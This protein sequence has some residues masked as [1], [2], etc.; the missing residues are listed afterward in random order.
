MGVQ[1]G[2]LDFKR[3]DLPAFSALTKRG[4]PF[5]FCTSYYEGFAGDC[6]LT[7]Y[8]DGSYQ[9]TRYLLEHGHRELWYLVTDD[10]AI[11]VTKDRLDGYRR[12]YADLQIPHSPDWIIRCRHINGESGYQITN[13][14]LDSRPLPDGILVLNDYMTF[15]VIRALQER[16]LHIPND[17]S[18]AGYDDVF[19]S[20]PAGIPLTTVRQDL[21]AISYHCVNMLL[22]K[23]DPAFEP[24]RPLRQKIRPTLVVRN[25]TRER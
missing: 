18:V 4:A 3:N 6:V 1:T 20:K 19:Y 16:G 7:D 9:L 13:E 21:E 12:A 11:P 17:I 14:L 8:A 25:T 10:L 23:I 15:G 5:V 24:G 22:S 2:R